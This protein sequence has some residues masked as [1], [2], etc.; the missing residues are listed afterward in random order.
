MRLKS[1]NERGARHA[2]SSAASGGRT[3]EP[4]AS[5]HTASG[6]PRTGARAGVTAELPAQEHAAGRASGPERT[7][8]DMI[9]S[10]KSTASFDIHRRP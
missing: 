1:N 2:G 6:A 5:Q 4:P 7:K 8:M 9:R 3:S 10:R